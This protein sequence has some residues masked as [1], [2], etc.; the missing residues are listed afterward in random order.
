VRV[1]AKAGGWRE[2][3]IFFEKI[4]ELGS[5]LVGHMRPILTRRDAAR[6]IQNVGSGFSRIS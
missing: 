3:T 4:A 1:G 2:G 6:R 5:V